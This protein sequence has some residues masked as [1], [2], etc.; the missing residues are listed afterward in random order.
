MDKMTEQ[1]LYLF[2]LHGYLVV[3]NA[4]TSEQVYA[5]NQILDEHIAEKMKPASVLAEGCVI[6]FSDLR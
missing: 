4:L 2:D 5:L 3:P 6:K 1:E